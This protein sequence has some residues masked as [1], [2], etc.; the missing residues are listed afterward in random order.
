VATNG[1]VLNNAGTFTISAWVNL[2]AT[3]NW[4]TAVSQDGNQTSGF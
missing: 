3:G 1:P 4:S 2:T